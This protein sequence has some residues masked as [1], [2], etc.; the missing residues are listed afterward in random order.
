MTTVA[1]SD[2]SSSSSAVQ[3]ATPNI[4]NQNIES[5]PKE[6]QNI[7]QGT[8]PV[9]VLPSKNTTL[10]TVSLQQQS[11]VVSS[12]LPETLAP[13]NVL[14]SLPKTTPPK[15]LETLVTEIN[16]KRNLMRLLDEELFKLRRNNMDAAD[17]IRLNQEHMM[18]RQKD[19]KQLLDNYTEHIRLRRA[20]P[21]DAGT[22]HKKLQDLKTMI[23]TL[24][25]ALAKRCDPVI[26]TKAISTFWVNLNEAILQLGNPLPK[27]RIEMLTEKFLMDVLVQNMNYNVFTGLKISQPYTQLQ[28]WFERYDA[29]FCTRFRQEMAKVVVSGNKPGSDIQQ[30]IQKL[31]KRMYNSLYSSLLKAF[32]FMDQKCEESTTE[33]KDYYTAMLRNM[34]D[35]ASHIGYAMR[36]QEVEIAAAA[37][38][39]GTEQLDLKTMVDEDGQTSG[40]IQFCVCPPFIMYGNRVEILEKARVLCSPLSNNNNT[41]TTATATTSNTN[42]NTNINTNIPAS[43]NVSS[44]V[45]AIS[46]STATTTNNI[47]S[48]ASTASS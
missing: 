9:S 24:S 19:Q 33:N 25:V 14:P 2:S 40:I 18:M 4:A 5:K 35:H 28:I 43:D 3:T 38:G 21:D 45:T 48:T 12:S 17:K 37:V 34:V 16:Q 26:A 46:A 15:L 23:K 13:S 31:N 47:N 41:I 6:L 30:E 32:P 27:N 44:T 29:S 39:E 42:T 36:G 7:Q 10:E 20:T 22:I 11:T 8:E 1:T